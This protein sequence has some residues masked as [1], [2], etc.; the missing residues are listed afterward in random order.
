[1]KISKSVRKTAADGFFRHIVTTLRD[2]GL[3]PRNGSFTGCDEVG[4]DEYG[5]PGFSR[6]ELPSESS[7]PSPIGPAK[8]MMRGFAF[9]VHYL[10]IGL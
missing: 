3:D 8:M 7:F 6:Q 4:I 5:Q 9:T 2:T 10:L 1:M